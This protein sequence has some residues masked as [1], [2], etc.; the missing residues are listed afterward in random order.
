MISLKKLILESNNDNQYLE[1]IKNKDENF[2]QEMV[3]IAA[4]RNGYNIGPVYHNTLS[5]EDFYIFK[6]NIKK[7]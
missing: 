3:E 5:N 7:T 2:V 4:K 1:L 6:P